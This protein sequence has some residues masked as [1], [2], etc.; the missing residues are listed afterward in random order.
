MILGNENFFTEKNEEEK[1]ETTEWVNE[2]EG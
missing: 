1:R 2:R